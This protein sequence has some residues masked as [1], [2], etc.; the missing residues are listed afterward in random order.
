MLNLT[1][2]K[3]K[4]IVILGAGITGLSAAYFLGRRNVSVS[5]FEKE[6]QPGGLC[7]SIKTNGFVFDYSGHLLHFRH[8]WTKRFVNS[9]LKN[10][11]K[12]HKRRSFIYFK[13]QFVP[14]PFQT[15]FAEINDKK[16]VDDCRR[17]LIKAA[18]SNKKSASFYSW[19]RNCF[20]RGICENFLYPYNEKL[21]QIPLKDLA[22]L[23]VEKF[24]VMPDKKDLTISGR[25]NQGYNSE[26]YY[27]KK[28]GI[29][30]L[31]QSLA[32]N[33]TSL[34]LN[35][36]V[37]K[38]DIQAKEV[39][40][41]NGVK[42]KYDVLITTIPLPELKNIV[43]G[44]NK[45]VESD[46][47]ALR[48]LSIYLMNIGLNK[49]GIPKIHWIYYP[50]KTIPYFRV[51]FYH[52]F[53]S[54][55]GPNSKGSLYAETSVLNGSK[56]KKRDLNRKMKSALKATKVITSLDEMSCLKDCFID[57]AYPID[58]KNCKKRVLR[59]NRFLSEKDIFSCGRF[60]GWDY[61][62]IEDC[63]VV[64]KEIAECVS[65]KV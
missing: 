14:Y 21:W 10:N 65:R 2:M 1:I 61:S 33:I 38:I 30:S 47:S 29:E 49:K 63:I 50:Q 28:G 3:K 16:I 59:I 43:L 60:G 48:W 51:G 57:Y 62:S 37:K 9:L 17:G 34:Y 35:H 5:A 53:S 25:M 8:Q 13:G 24:I 20:G 27:P 56:I 36:E 46:L 55:L 54:S 19:A 23:A 45:S 6:S 7:R 40:F 11:L 42:V 4:K 52:N 41:A 22:P 26:F 32:K 18:S 44:L 12:K 58:D 64:A 15:N 31:A 39:R